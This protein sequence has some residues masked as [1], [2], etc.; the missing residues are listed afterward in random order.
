[1][2]A[3]IL[4]GDDSSGHTTLVKHFEILQTRP[5]PDQNAH[6]DIEDALTRIPQTQA[7]GSG[8]E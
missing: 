3:A 2:V 4:R 8:T 7:I 5:Q 1:M 6:M